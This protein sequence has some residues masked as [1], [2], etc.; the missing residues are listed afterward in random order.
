MATATNNSFRIAVS[1][2]RLRAELHVEGAPPGRDALVEKLTAIGIPVTSQV[3]ARINEWVRLR[4]QNQKP[5]VPFLIAEGQ[6]PGAGQPARFEPS[7]QAGVDPAKDEDDSVDFHQ[8][9]IQTARSGE[10]FGMLMPAV[11]G[12][13]GRDVFGKE[14]P[15]VNS[16]DL[17]LGNG[18]RLGED[19]RSL[20]ATTDGMVSL[21]HGRLEVISVVE[22]AG[23]VDFATGNIESPTD[24]LIR[25]TVMDT[26]SVRSAGSI[27]VGGAV[28]SATVE[29]GGEVMVHGGIAGMPD[30]R[31]KAGGNI[32]VKFCEEAQLEAGGD[33]VI[34]R[35]MMNCRL[36]AGGLLKVERGAVVGGRVHARRGAVIKQLGNDS[37]LKTRIS[38]GVDP[39][40]VCAGREMDKSLKKKREAAAKI[41]ESVQPLLAQLKRLTPEQRE[42]ATELLYQADT[43]DQEV[44]ET[45]RRRA[46]SREEANSCSDA[47]L[48]VDGRIHA[49]VTVI[50]GDRQVTLQQERRGPLKV[51]RKLVGRVEEIV[52]IDRVSGSTNVLV[53][54]EYE[55]EPADG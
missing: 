26:F 34:H 19:G 35:E 29:A 47:E 44:A 42:K 8:T 43:L 50:F 48:H 13:P 32:S 39:A 10:Q 5:A 12:E 7:S 6:S 4:E 3:E 11:P 25:G 45:E 16:A 9:H 1:K 36:R 52:L 28:E 33:I 22:V 41:R 17:E 54:R 15:A 14:I 49:G 53:S 55:P 23:N 30:G 21:R 31:V 46:E 2:D 37:G 20:F 38:I 51:A 27:T 40:V 18:V 24:V